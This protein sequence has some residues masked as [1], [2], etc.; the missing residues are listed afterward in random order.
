MSAKTITIE[1]L[2]PG[3]KVWLIRWTRYTCEVVSARITDFLIGGSKYGIDHEYTLTRYGAYPASS[4]FTSKRAA[5]AECKRRN[6]EAS[7]Q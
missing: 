1:V 2:R 6:E 5:Q 3:T 7:G 4:V